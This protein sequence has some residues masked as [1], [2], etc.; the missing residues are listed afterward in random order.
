MKDIRL[1]NSLD[2]ITEYG[3]RYAH[4]SHPIKYIEIELEPEGTF[5][6]FGFVSGEEPTSITNGNYVK[7]WKTFQG[8]LRYLKKCSE[9]GG[10][11]MKKFKNYEK[12]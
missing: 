4:I 8:V 2:E 12:I 10:W 6:V 9:N 7:E 5:S 11:G 3:V 1:I